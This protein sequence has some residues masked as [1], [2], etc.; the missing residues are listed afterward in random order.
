[1]ETPPSD[2][3][4]RRFCLKMSGSER[5]VVWV[6]R[7]EQVRL[8]EVGLDEVRARSLAVVTF[9]LPEVVGLEEHDEVVEY[10]LKGHGHLIG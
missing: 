10:A 5:R 1:M 9:D 6:G 3:D 2:D 8:D 7:A 4:R